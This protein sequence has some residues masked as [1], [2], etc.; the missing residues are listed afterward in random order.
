MKEKDFPELDITY[1]DSACM[2]L[3]PKQVIDKIE[4]YYTEYP[5]CP[6]RS[7][8]EKARKATD[9]LE[10]A[11]EKVASLID[12][13]PENIVFNSGTTEGIN[14]VANGFNFEKVILSDREHNSNLLPWQEYNPEFIS[15]VDG[16]DLNEL[17]EK[18]EP[19]ALV[20]VVHVSNLDGYELPIKE[21]SKIVREND[22]YLLI[23][24]AQS[25][26]HQPFSVKEIKPDFVAFSGHKI[27]GPSGTGAL[28]VSDTVKDRLQP[29]H[30]GGGAVSD[31]DRVSA[32]FQDFPHRMEAGLPNLAG[33][34]GL[35]EAASYL[36]EVGM[37]RIEEHE[38]ML[39]S[40]LRQ[41]LQ[42]INGVDLVGEKGT[43][44]ESFRVEN[45]DSTQVAQ[46]LDKQDI[47]VRSG[48]HCLHMMHNER[49]IEPSV[50]ASLHLYNNEEDIEELLDEV[51]SIAQLS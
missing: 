5:A 25:I 35:G 50:R 31:A 22:A 29:L 13:E 26:P 12:A 47:A 36:Q 27:L 9:E 17:E 11:R 2:S 41:G 32:K 45:V 38:K 34:I 16:F 37:E 21:I 15:T 30:K 6:G 8:H 19:E 44:I 4:E 51:R 43:G 46:L 33:F 20:S 42:E 40:K 3:R 10:S 18:I 24:A 39:T 49:D 48:Y 28:F 23:D 14:T 7:G 1:L